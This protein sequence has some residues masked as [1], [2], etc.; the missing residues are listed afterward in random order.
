MVVGVSCLGL[1]VTA[2]VVP[3]LAAR[4]EQ[5]PVRTA[6]IEEPT[7][8]SVVPAAQAPPPAEKDEKKAAKRKES[9]YSD[10][11]ALA[12]FDQRWDDETH[13]HIT[14]IRTTGTYLRIYTDLPDSKD[15]SPVSLRLCERGMEY[16]AELG[17]KKRVVFVQARTGG[18]GNPVLANVLGP[19]DD[20]CRVTYP[21]PKS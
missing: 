14:D 3:L 16:L 4:G 20:D 8:A 10:K 21:K 6:S 19:K 12:Y 5:A 18:N 2:V 11:D 17:V 9:K 15:N 1:G 7:T 13:R